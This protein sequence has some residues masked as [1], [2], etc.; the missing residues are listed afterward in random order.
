MLIAFWAVKLRSTVP[1][2]LLQNPMNQVWGT[3]E[4][5]A[6]SPTS[7]YVWKVLVL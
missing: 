3:F 6:T 4:A 5:Q 7:V 2:V 1:I